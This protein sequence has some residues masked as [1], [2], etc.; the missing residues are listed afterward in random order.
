M[1]CGVILLFVMLYRLM[2]IAAAT[3]RRS[4]FHPHMAKGEARWSQPVRLVIVA[5]FEVFDVSTGVPPT[6]TW[7]WK[8]TARREKS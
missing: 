4:I 7:L 3:Y 2:Q 6:L 8:Q 5:V 1:G